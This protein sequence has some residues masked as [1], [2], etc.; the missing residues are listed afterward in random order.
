MHI[1][2][3]E[4]ERLIETYCGDMPLADAVDRAVDHDWAN[5]PRTRWD[6]RNGVTQDE[7]DGVLYGDPNA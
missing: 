3:S 1:T 2:K 4:A 5:D 7:V 6:G